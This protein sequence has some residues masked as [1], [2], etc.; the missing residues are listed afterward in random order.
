V[1][2]VG[3]VLVFLC[4][5]GIGYAVSEGLRRQ[6]AAQSLQLD[7]N[8]VDGGVYGVRNVVDGDTIVLENALHVRYLGMNAPETGHFVRDAAPLA[9]EA[10]ARNIELL[11]GNR[12]RLHLPSNHPLDVHGRV[13][14]RV[15]AV[16]EN[17][18]ESETDVGAVL[19]QEGLARTMGIDV[20]PEHVR[21]LKT[22]EQEAKAAKRGIWGLEDK[23]RAA[24]KPYCAAA[25]STIYHLTA[26]PIAQRIKAANR[27]EYESTDAAEA[28]GL[29]PCSK[30]VAKVSSQ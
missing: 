9:A 6:P 7:L 27:H 24:G 13:L 3:Y 14:A 25:S 8:V 20:A 28:A 30:C 26:C 17:T 4:G 23:A 1:R 12:V 29:K 15:F 5:G 21:A 16:S 11:K 22:L 18:S 10:T 19:L 2:I